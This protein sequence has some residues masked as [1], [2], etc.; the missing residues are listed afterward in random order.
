M[1]RYELALNGVG[2]IHHGIGPY[3][4]SGEPEPLHPGESV[5]SDPAKG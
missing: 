4:V 2:R 5:L 1:A 3:G